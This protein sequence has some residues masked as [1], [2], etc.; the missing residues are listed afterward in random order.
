MADLGSWFARIQ[1]V[2]SRLRDL[3]A[4]QSETVSLTRADP[5]TGEQ[6]EAGQAWGH[7]AE[8]VQFWVEQAGD[9]I[10]AYRGEPIPFGRIRSDPTRLAGIEQ[11]RHLG[12]EDLWKEVRSD[13]A[14][15]RGF[16]EALPRG[17]ES[18]VGLHPTLGEIPAE[19]IIEDFLIGHLEEH[20]A[21]LEGLA[22]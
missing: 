2:E 16:L 3:A 22:K 18:S 8:F 7:M 20:A 6:W 21:Q 4:R 14:D 10:D 1:A 5:A 17:W 19:R 12:I 13:L 15:L 11:G 9:V